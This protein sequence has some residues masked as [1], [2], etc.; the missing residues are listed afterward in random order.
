MNNIRQELDE[1]NRLLNLSSEEELDYYRAVY[2]EVF[3]NP[4]E[5]KIAIGI[6]TKGTTDQ[7]LQKRPKYKHRR[8]PPDYRALIAEYS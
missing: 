8:F 2:K 1:V 7:V 3:L 4:E 6:K 5:H